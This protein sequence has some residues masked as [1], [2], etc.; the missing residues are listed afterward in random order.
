MQTLYDY[1]FSYSLVVG[2][3]LSDYGNEPFVM[4]RILNFVEE[5][6]DII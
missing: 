6:I 2:L 3:G 5:V 4:L 1:I